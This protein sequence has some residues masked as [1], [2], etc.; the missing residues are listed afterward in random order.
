MIRDNMFV[1]TFLIEAEEGN[2]SEADK[3]EYRRPFAAPG[4]DRRP[5]LTWPRQIPIDGS[6]ADVDAT[7]RAFSAWLA[8]SD[9]PKLWVRGDPGFI[10]N[11]RFAE[12]CAGL[13]NQTDVRVKGRHFLQESSGPEI[14]DAVASFVRD[15]R[16]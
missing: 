11:G 15:L 10:T 3:A 5:T 9:V 14:G 7:V 8:E 2:L 6:P 4:E 13:R 12:F 1:E 16:R